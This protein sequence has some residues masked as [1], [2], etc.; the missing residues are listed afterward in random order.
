MGTRKIGTR[1][2]GTRKL[3]TVKTGSQAFCSGRAT[4]NAFAEGC[5]L[6][7]RTADKSSPF[8]SAIE[9][10]S[11]AYLLPK[12]VEVIYPGWYGM[13]NPY[14]ARRFRQGQ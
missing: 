10:Y 5:T 2:I 8:C 1:V 11:R 4:L 12:V 13:L 14:L 3:G 7:V 9:V 6:A